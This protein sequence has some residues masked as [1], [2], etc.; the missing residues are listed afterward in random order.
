VPS[1]IVGGDANPV[2]LIV[3]A[4]ANEASAFPVPK[5]L[6]VYRSTLQEVGAP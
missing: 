3:G 4:T 5:D 1:T 2:P 6:Q